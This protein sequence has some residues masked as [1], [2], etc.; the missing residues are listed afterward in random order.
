MNKPTPNWDNGSFVG[1]RPSYD[2]IR[3]LDAAGLRFLDS[4]IANHKLHVSIIITANKIN[5][6]ARGVLSDPI[7]VIPDQCTVSVVETRTNPY[8]VLH[9]D[10]PAFNIR[11]QEL[12]NLGGV[13]R[14]YVPPHMAIHACWDPQQALPQA[15]T[16]P[17]VFDF[18]YTEGSLFPA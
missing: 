4:R 8:L 3:K 16:F 10:H 17:L 14:G 13:C 6:P 2:T 18:E 11:R 12:I 15:P 9:L 5:L 1:L 7:V